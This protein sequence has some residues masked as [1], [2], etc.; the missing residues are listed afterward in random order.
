MQS[1]RQSHYNVDWLASVWRITTVNPFVE[2]YDVKNNKLKERHIAPFPVAL[3]QRLISFF[4]KKGDYV[5][6]PFCGSGTTNF[7]ALSLFRK[8]IGYDLEQKYIDMARKRCGN[9]GMFVCGSSENMKKVYSNSIQL[10]ITSP[11]Y[12]HL[13]HYS[14][15][16]DNIGNMKDPYPALRNVFKEVYRVLKEKGVL[17]VNVGGVPIKKTGYWTTFPFDVL[18]ICL[19][20]GFKFKGSVIWDKGLRVNKWNID[21]REISENHEYVWVL[22][23]GKED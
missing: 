12:M 5:L 14:D 7:A 16:P 3:P 4:S 21:N 11:P 1:V 10:C 8:T 20:I 18:Q 17:C 9:N 15:N 23:K 2:N 19:D 6:D 22:E 13:R